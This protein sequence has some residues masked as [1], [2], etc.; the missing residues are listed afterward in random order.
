MS[1]INAQ[2]HDDAKLEFSLLMWLTFGVFLVAIAV[3][4]VR[5]GGVADGAVEELDALRDDGENRDAEEQA[6]H[7]RRGQGVRRPGNPKV[8]RPQA[9]QVGHPGKDPPGRKKTPHERPQT[10]AGQGGLP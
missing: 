10:E 8:L 5:V 3:G 4:W 2:R 1:M 9:N 6:C 7:G